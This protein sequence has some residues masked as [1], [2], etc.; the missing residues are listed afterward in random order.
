M[1]DNKEKAFMDLYKF[2]K[3]YI[4]SQDKSALKKVEIIVA[5]KIQFDQAL[6]KMNSENI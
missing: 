3:A 1:I 4:P 6:L 5:D 2:V